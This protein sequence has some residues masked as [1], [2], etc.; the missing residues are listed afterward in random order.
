MLECFRKYFQQKNFADSFCNR[1]CE[2]NGCH[3]N[4]PARKS[5]SCTW[6]TLMRDQNLWLEINRRSSGTIKAVFV[7]FPHDVVPHGE[8]KGRP[9]HR[10]TL[11][12][13]RRRPHTPPPHT[14]LL[15]PNLWQHSRWHIHA[16]VA[17]V[18]CIPSCPLM[19]TPICAV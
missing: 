9:C 14:R 10:D 15:P 16:G 12:S 2:C 11:S 17:E 13:L 6:V 1:C 4:K 3:V 5:S 19:P 8:A 7:P 18:T